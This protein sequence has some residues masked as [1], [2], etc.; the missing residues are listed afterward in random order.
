MVHLLRNSFHYAARQDWNKIAKLL[1]PVYS[2]PT[3]QAA[4]RRV[5]MALMPLDPTVIGHAALVHR[6]NAA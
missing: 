1:K 3:E 5:Y 4:L 2:A 6:A